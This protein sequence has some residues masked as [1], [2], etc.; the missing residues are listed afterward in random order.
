MGKLEM[1][2]ESGASATVIGEHQVRAIT[3]KNPRPDIKYEVADGT[4][5]ANMG[6]K[7]LVPAQTTEQHSDSRLKSLR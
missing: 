1:V 4:H 7:H 3:A 5:I 2:V 6:E